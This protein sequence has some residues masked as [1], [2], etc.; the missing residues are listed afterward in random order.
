M[1]VYVSVVLSLTKSK[2]DVVRFE[3]AAAAAATRRRR[4]RGR[5][6]CVGRISNFSLIVK[7]P[8]SPVVITCTDDD[9]RRCTRFGFRRPFAPAT[10]AII[11]LISPHHVVV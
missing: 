10:L 7:T 9:D 5:H 11:V 8:I 3:N 4:I 2:R 1:C 6:M